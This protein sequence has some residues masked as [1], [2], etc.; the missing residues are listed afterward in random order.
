MKKTLILLLLLL[1]LVSFG[2]ENIVGTV[3]ARPKSE[4]M[5]QNENPLSKS[6]IAF[7]HVTVGKDT[8]LPAFSDSL[9]PVRKIVF[10]YLNS[11]LSQKG[12]DYLFIEKKL[13]KYAQGIYYWYA[14][15]S[16]FYPIMD[17][18]DTIS[19]NSTTNPFQPGG[20]TNQTTKLSN[21]SING[22]CLNY[23]LQNINDS[24]WGGR[25]YFY[26]LIGRMDYFFPVDSCTNDSLPYGPLLWYQ[27]DTI[28]RFVPDSTVIGSCNTSIAQMSPV[29]TVS[30]FPNPVLHNLTIN[31]E[32]PIKSLKLIN[33]YGQQ[34]IKRQDLQTGEMD[35]DISSL[36]P[37][38]YLLQ[39]ISED[40]HYYVKKVI[41]Q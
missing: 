39:V 28:G 34:I 14:R 36:S 37:G 32:M 16:L 29:Q 30:I 33:I 27:D 7:I 25:Q 23:Y 1:P 24:C 40:N 11:D 41:K 35:V 38:I 18:A 6:S 21:K 10:T 31:A 12:V 17:Y 8:I 19:V 15:D 20:V 5:Y 22:L 26:E 2:Q 4:W 13:P 3:F 9:V